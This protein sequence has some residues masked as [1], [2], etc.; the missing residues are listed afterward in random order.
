VL[1]Y[2]LPSLLSAGISGGLA[3]KNKK[4]HLCVLRVSAVKKKIDIIDVLT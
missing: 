2:S 4:K 1:F 3:A